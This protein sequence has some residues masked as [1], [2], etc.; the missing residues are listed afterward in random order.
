MFVS[1]LKI[2]CNLFV[3]SKIPKPNAERHVI[4]GAWISENMF[5][6]LR[7]SNANIREIF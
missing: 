5:E 7:K 3:S 6:I 4:R 2:K 1:A